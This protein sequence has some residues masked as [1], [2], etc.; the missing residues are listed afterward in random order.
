MLNLERIYSQMIFFL[1][2]KCLFSFISFDTIQNT[3]DHGILFYL[4]EAYVYVYLMI[5]I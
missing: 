3:V 2:V 4:T 1:D 5:N